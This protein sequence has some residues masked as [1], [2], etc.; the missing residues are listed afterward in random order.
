MP[1]NPKESRG[2][3]QRGSHATVGMAERCCLGLLKTPIPSREK[4]KTQ[5]KSAEG[6]DQEI[7][8]EVRTNRAWF[9]S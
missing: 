2:K 3:V 7:Q 1:K 8:N 4:R 5:E 9:R 6:S